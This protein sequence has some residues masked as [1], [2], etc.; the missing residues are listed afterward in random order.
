MALVYVVF[1]AINN[2][3]R[4]ILLVIGGIQLNKLTVMV[5]RPQLLAHPAVVI[6][7]HRIGRIQDITGRAV[8]LFQTHHAGIAKILLVAEDVFH[9]G[10][11]PAIDRLV[12]IADHRDMTGVTGQHP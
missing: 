3:T 11:T 6:T 1:Y 9:P 5:I 8:I 10:A 12:V 2:E 7:D 4:L